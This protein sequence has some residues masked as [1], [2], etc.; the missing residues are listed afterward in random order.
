MVRVA[1]ELAIQVSRKRLSVYEN[2]QRA[3]GRK[4]ERERE[5]VCE[6]SERLQQQK[7]FQNRRH[8]HI[9]ILQRTGTFKDKG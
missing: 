7:A 6:K 5:R 4:S 9:P 2:T 8:D 1:S 3:K